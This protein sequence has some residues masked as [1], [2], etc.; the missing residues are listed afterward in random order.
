MATSCG[1]AVLEYDKNEE[2]DAGYLGKFGLDPCC[3]SSCKLIG[4]SECRYEA[5]E[6]LQCDITGVTKITLPV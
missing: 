6:N 1:N 2:C 5:G 3:S 4:S